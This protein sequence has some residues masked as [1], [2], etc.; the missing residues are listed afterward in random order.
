MKLVVDPV[1]NIRC[2]Y[3]EEIDLRT[4]GDLRIVRASHVE[5]GTDGSWSADLSPV[6]GPHLGPFF[7]RNQAIAAEVR[8]LHD[9]WL[10]APISNSGRRGFHAAGPS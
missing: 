5:P 8:W 1:G 7:Q 10:V 6:G 2:I 4:L 3:T 9:H